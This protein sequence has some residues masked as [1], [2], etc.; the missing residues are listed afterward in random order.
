MCR[1]KKR[2]D[3]HADKTEWIIYSINEK[4]KWKIIG[5]CSES[6]EILDLVS[7]VS[8]LTIWTESEKIIEIPH[9]MKE[10]SENLTV[11][12]H[13]EG[14]MGRAMQ[15]ATYLCSLCERLTECLVRQ[16]D[17]TCQGIGS[18]GGPWSSMF[19]SAVIQRR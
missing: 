7:F 18:C 16:R 15:Q 17:K 11:M 8:L 14:K 9:I 19:W 1:K 12:G 10:V 3:K 6:N 4:R 2:Q 13:I 5:G